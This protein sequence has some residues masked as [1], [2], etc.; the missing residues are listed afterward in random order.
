M[1]KTAVAI[2]CIVAVIAVI[3]ALK[4]KDK[5][6]DIN[7]SVSSS[8]S[9]IAGTENDSAENTEEKEN[10]QENNK[11]EIVTKDP[12]ALVKITL[13]LS[14]YDAENKSD[15]SGFFKKSS[16]KSCTVDES[17]K[18]FTVTMKSLNHDFM[19]T[20]VG[21][22]VIK[23]LAA[24]LDSEEYPYVKEIGKYNGD[25]SEI[26]MIVDRKG[27]ESADNSDVLVNLITSCG[28]F[29]QLYTTEN[30]YSCKV[31]ITC[32]ES[33]E[34]LKEAFVKQSNKDFR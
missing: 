10:N 27:F 31:T 14:F 15:T 5:P 8:S 25:F 20:N 32:N 28:I 29:Y 26:E 3:F 6:N 1:K 7:T 22:Q 33:G 30:K 23:N 4:G 21:L 12:D 19:L 11:D 13:P 2:V 16:Y 34:T 17:D 24:L 18:T 9:E